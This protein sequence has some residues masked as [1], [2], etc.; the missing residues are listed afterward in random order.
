MGAGFTEVVGMAI[1]FRLTGRPPEETKKKEMSSG[2]E[3]EKGK[4]KK[5]KGVAPLIG[6]ESA[7]GFRMTSVISYHFLLFSQRGTRVGEV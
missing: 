7:K 2:K 3:R 1:R 6:A 5:K 4:K